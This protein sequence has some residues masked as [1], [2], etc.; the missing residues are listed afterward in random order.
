[1]SELEHDN[2]TEIQRADVE[3]RLLDDPALPYIKSRYR[4]DADFLFKAIRQEQELKIDSLT[5]IGGHWAFRDEVTQLIERAHYEPLSIETERF[6][7]AHIDI[8][9]LKTVNDN[10]GHAEGDR[11]LKTVAA[12]LQRLV[13]PVIDKVYRIGGDEFAVVMPHFLLEG[14]LDEEEV[15]LGKVDQLESGVAVDIAVE[16]FPPE[17]P[18]GVSVGIALL[19]AYESLDSLMDRADQLMYTQKKLHRIDNTEII[20]E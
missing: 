6:A 13:R 4:H 5:G 10:Y 7:L 15:L 9:R 16:D 3:L 17:L 19:G 12:S 20:E 1:M 18:L 14:G 8:D 11:L 2:S